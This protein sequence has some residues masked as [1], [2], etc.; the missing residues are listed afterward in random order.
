VALATKHNAWLFPIFLLAHYLWMR[1]GD[2]RRLRLPRIPL[3]FVSMATLGPLVLFIL[4]PWLWHAPVERTRAWVQRHTQHEHYNF[5]YLGRNWNLPPKEPRLES[6]A[7][8]LPLR[9]DAVHLARDDPGALGGRHGGVPAPPPSWRAVLLD[10][11]PTALR[12]SWLRPGAD[13]D[14]APGVFLAIHIAGPI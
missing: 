1:S 4:W 6:S 5:E 12:P 2:L 11:V 7:R 10:D 9:L 14:R 8:N 13:V 3:A